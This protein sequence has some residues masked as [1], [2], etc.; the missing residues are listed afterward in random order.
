ML[1]TLLSLRLRALLSVLT[2]AGRSRK[3]QSRGR[4]IGFAL[5][6]VY[7]FGALG[8]L[9]WHIF[10]MLSEPFARFGLGAVYFT[11]AGILSFALMLVGSVFTAKSQLFEAR[12]NEL[13]LSLPIRPLDILLSRLFLLWL[14]AFVTGLPVAVPCL[15][16]WSRPLGAAGWLAVALLWIVLL[17]LLCL[18]LSALIGWIIHRIAARFGHKP[19]VTVLLWLLFLGGYTWLSFRWHGMLEKLAANPQALAGKLKAAAPLVW[20]GKAVAEGDLLSLGKLTG[21]IVPLFALVC[22]LL[23]KTFIRTAT[24]RREG[25]KKRYVE[26]TARPRSPGA[27]LLVRELRRLWATPAY[28]FNS[29]LGVVMALLGTAVLLFKAGDI[30]SALAAMPDAG[31][32]AAVLQQIALPGL[33]FL[34][35]MIFFTA[36]SVSLEGK[37]LWLLQALPVAPREVLRAKLR[38]QLL[39]AVPPLLLL[40]AAVA[41][42][43]RMRGALLALALLLPALYSLFIGLVGLVM[44]LRYPNL[45]WINE[46]Q[47]VKSGASVLLTMLIGMGSVAAPLLLFVLLQGHVSAVSL[48]AGTAALVLLTSL[49]LA[50]WL[51]RRG[52]ERFRAL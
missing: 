15:I 36:P 4:L 23:A 35:V 33:C 31:E 25:A 29:G 7:S 28:L 9:F 37:S 26:R 48:G 49:L 14:I 41:A 44:N 52:E 8:F 5:L 6:M 32:L 51:R 18:S 16:A 39:L 45:D 13:L 21:L 40:S 17:P 1:K 3:K 22:F 47:A 2:G 10:D 42:V 43:L 34:S 19:F 12:D 24:A 20:L 38:M 46:T 30:R 50:H 27:A 11:L